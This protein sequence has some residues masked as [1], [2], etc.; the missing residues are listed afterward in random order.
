MDAASANAIYLLTLLSVSVVLLLV[1]IGLQGMF[2]TKELGSAWN[3]GPRDQ[4]KQ[5]EGLLAGRAE[6][7]SKNFQETYPAF[8]GLLLAM[9]LTGDASGWG[10]V[11][12]TIWLLA[13]IG[14][15]PLYLAGIPYV[16]SVVWLISVFGLLV[17][18]IGLFQ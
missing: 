17:M 6:R 10:L 12:G 2:A 14:Y 16:R 4:G 3:A 7:A 11:G 1:Q 5:P 8:V 13:R 18:M 15:I 9:I